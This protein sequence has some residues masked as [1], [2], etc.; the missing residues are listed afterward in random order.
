MI[1]LSKANI[2][3]D[4]IPE[5]LDYAKYKGIPV[6]EAL[7]SSV[8]QTTIRERAEERRSA[9]I[10]N[11]GKTKSSKAQISDDALLEMAEKGTL[12]EDVDFDKLVRARIAKAKAK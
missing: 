1:A 2:D 6:A 4:D 9:E 5:V 12:P 7:K 10:A 8:I 11:T 3:V